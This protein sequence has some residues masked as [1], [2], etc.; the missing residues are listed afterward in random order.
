MPHHL[1]VADAQTR[2]LVVG[3]GPAGLMAAA[4]LGSHGIECLI[5]EPRTDVSHSRPRAKTTSIRTM[6]HLRR[7]GLAE[8]L[9]SAAPLKP[10]WSQKVTFCESLAGTSITEFD[11]AFGLSPSRLPYASE[12]GQQVAQPVF[13]DVLRRHVATLRSVRALWG[14]RLVDLKIEQNH[15]TAMVRRPT[16]EVDRI[17]ARYVLGCDGA[18]STVR[19]AMNASLVGRSD[20]RPNFNV[21]FRAPSLDTPLEPAVQYWVTGAAQPGIIGRLD[22]AGTWWA[23]FPGLTAEQGVARLPSLLAGLAGRQIDFEVVA[24]DM[25]IANML[26]VDTFQRDCVFLAGDSAH[27]NPPWGGHGYNTAIGDVVNICWKIAAVEQGWAGTA[28][29]DSYEVERRPVVDQTVRIAEQNMA[30]LPGGMSATADAIRRSKCI[31]FH[32]LGLVLGYSYAGSPIVQPGYSENSEADPRRYEPNAS[33]GSRLPHMWLRDGTSLYDHLGAGMS[34]LVPDA[35]TAAVRALHRGC[36]E[37]GLPVRIVEFPEDYPWADAFLLVRPD[38]HIAWRSH[39]IRDIDLA[40]AL[41]LSS[42]P[43][44]QLGARTGPFELPKPVAG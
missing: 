29:L 25:W 43:T 9:R 1:A 24:T 23:S 34:L 37:S 41:A 16:G 15:A 44:S 35:T 27:L 6:E 18:S 12:T 20:A 42:R 26:V 30:A 14:H 17:Q 13:E 21:L 39:D 38:Q 5:V 33:P 36:R 19:E 40:A 31:E 2:V 32:S 28:L 4:E 10:A 8:A 7:L 11:G 22:L 3:G